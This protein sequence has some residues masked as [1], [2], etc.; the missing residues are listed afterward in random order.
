[1]RIPLFILSIVLIAVGTEVLSG[2][3]WQSQRVYKGPDGK[4]VYTK[5]SIGNRIPDFSY[6]GF[7]NGNEPIPYVSSVKTVGPVP[8]DNT[9]HLQQAIDAVAA[10]PLGGNGIR[11]ALQ[12]VPGLYRIYGTL[13]INASGVVLRGSGQGAD[14]TKN[15]VLY[16]LGDTPHQRSVIVAGG[17]KT[18]RWK[19]KDPAV[20]QQNITSDTVYTGSSTFTVAD[21][22][23][24][25]VGDNI[26]IYHPCSA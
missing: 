7:R 12:L 22:S 3:T 14:T 26:I 4:L 8:G 13:R 21:A 18:S 15:T 5:D 6:A 24:Y 1:M 23:Q 20:A 17:G 9:A 2:Q 19:E 11:G 16:A 25:A 10:M